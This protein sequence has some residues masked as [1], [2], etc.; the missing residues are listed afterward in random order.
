MIKN[1]NENNNKPNINYYL[2]LNFKKRNHLMIVEFET[3][4]SQLKQKIYEYLKIDPNRYDLY[5]KNVKINSNDHRPIALLFQKEIEKN[6]LLFIVDKKRNK[7][8]S[9]IKPIFSITINSNSSPK[10][11]GQILNKFYEYKKCPYDAVIKNNIKGIYEVKFRKSI[12]ADEFKQFFDVN[13]NNKLKYN[14]DKIILPNINKAINDEYNNSDNNENVKNSLLK[15][16]RNNSVNYNE[17]CGYME[18][19]MPF[20]YINSDEKYFCDKI[21]DT[22]NWLYKKGFINNTGKYN[23]NNNYYVIKNYVRA[24]PSEP[25]ALHHFRDVY[26]KQWINERGFYP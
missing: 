10:K 15:N 16:R 11:F 23:I 5:Y 21:I 3:L 4:V 25:P 22:K 14:F 17:N 26:K 13:Y 12:F 2:N 9:S 20:K 7:S 24:T 8:F 1:I 6:P 19:I 18:K